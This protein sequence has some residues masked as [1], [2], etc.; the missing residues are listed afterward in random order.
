MGCRQSSKITKIVNAGDTI[1]KLGR[2]DAKHGKSQLLFGR[3]YED[4]SIE[5]DAFQ[6]RGRIMC[7][8]SA[9]C[10]AMK[11]APH[12]DEIVAVDINHLQISYAEQRF[13]GNIGFG[14]K[15]E[16]I[17]GLIR[18][19][20][21][22][23]GWWP[24]TVKE[25]VDLHLP[26]EQMSYWNRNLNT[27]RFQN[28]FDCMFS[29]KVLSMFYAPHLIN[30]LP[31]RLGTV[32]R[33]RMERCFSHHPNRSNP[34]VRSLLMGELSSDPVPPQAKH[35]QLIHSDAL[36]FLEKEPP[37]S[38]N[39]FTLSNILDGADKV[40]EQRLF[41]AIKRAA[42]PGAMIVLRSFNDI[43]PDSIVNRAVDDRSMIWGTVLV[44][45][46]IDL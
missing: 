1:W 25:F 23:V 34:F 28:L 45:P 26:H 22:L 6:Q 36:S 10:T 19:F 31:K 17:M 12:H 18:F 11:L 13:E 30:I 42:A 2:L 24:S 20:G 32:M 33:Y 8:A 37:Q 21:P 46:A 29:R 39:G 27:W 41:A 44:R 15:A 14:G 35:I 3:M 5:L 7:I 4:S 43:M 16:Y 9:G 38:F 40:Y